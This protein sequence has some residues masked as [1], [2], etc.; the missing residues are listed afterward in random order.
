MI[1]FEIEL[2][3]NNM[4]NVAL[5]GNDKVVREAKLSTSR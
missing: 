2:H 4:V 5:N 1:Y 3:L